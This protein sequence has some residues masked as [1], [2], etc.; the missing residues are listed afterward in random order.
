MTVT[1]EPEIVGLVKVRRV[2]TFLYN[3]CF[4]KVY[5]KYFKCEGYQ[6]GWPSQK[7]HECCKRSEYL[8]YILKNKASRFSRLS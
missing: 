1:D 2:L 3:I 5:Q 4:N 6:E 8:L 7:D